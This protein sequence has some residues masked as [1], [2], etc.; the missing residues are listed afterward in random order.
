MEKWKL[1]QLDK[2]E[3]K[4][5]ITMQKVPHTFSTHTVQLTIE[6]GAKLPI[7]TTPVDVLFYI[8]SGNGTVTVGE[9]EFDCNKGTY[10]ES[11]KDIP[12]GWENTGNDILKV[13][14]IKLN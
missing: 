3:G 8:I 11:P 13:L 10:I 12:H 5:G 7:H 9:E 1:D 6:S 2:L 4:K 14:V